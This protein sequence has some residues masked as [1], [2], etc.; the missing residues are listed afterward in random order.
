MLTVWQISASRPTRDID[1]LVHMSNDLDKIREM[2]AAICQTEVEDDGLVFDH[3]SVITERIAEDADYEGVRAT[4]D[5]VLATI[6]TPMQVDMGFSDVVTPSPVDITYPTVLEMPAPRLR[7]YNRETA[8]AEKF[9]AMVKIGQL[10][11][12]MKDFF[13]I[14]ALATNGPFNGK[15]LSQAISKTFERRGTEMDTDEACFTQDFA[16]SDGKSAQWRAFIQRGQL[17]N[18]P[19]DFTDVWN[20]VMAFLRPLATA[21]ESNQS[22]NMN[23]PEGGPW[24]AES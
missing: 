15:I 19:S 5:G 11:S 24:Q 12:R 22:F 8:I 21:I 3:T 1:F 6:K 23:W 13:D 17:K 14:W 2:V 10:N 4:F 18:A 7:S 9:E 16:G 20:K